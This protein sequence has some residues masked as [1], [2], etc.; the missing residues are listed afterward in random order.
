M[1]LI[2]DAPCHQTIFHLFS[3]TE[4]PHSPYP[5]EGGYY[6]GEAIIILR[7]FYVGENMHGKRSISSINI[8]S[9]SKIQDCPL[10][11]R[12]SCFFI[13]YFSFVIFQFLFLMFISNGPQLTTMSMFASAVAVLII[14]PTPIIVK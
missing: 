11:Y 13:F 6:R 10:M 8:G 9:N 3:S 1:V 7:K 12:M 14:M 4:L 2:S 5:S